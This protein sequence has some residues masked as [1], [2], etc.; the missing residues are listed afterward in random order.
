MGWPV[1]FQAT[2]DGKGMRWYD[3]ISGRWSNWEESEPHPWYGPCDS[4]GKNNVCS[5]CLL[6]IH[7]LVKETL[8]R[9]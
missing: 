7:N 8:Q 9:L 6:T 2:S 3:H 5:E 4:M 1:S